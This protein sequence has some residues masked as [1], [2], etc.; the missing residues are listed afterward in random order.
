MSSPV[1]PRCNHMKQSLR[2]SPSLNNGNQSNWRGVQQR[3][4]TPD[5]AIGVGSR[6]LHTAPAPCTTPLHPLRTA[7]QG[8]ERIRRDATELR[9]YVNVEAFGGAVWT[10]DTDSNRCRGATSREQ[11]RPRRRPRLQ[12]RHASCLLHNRTVD[13]CRR[14]CGQKVWAGCVRFRS[15]VSGRMLG[16]FEGPERTQGGITAQALPVIVLVR[17]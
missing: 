7:W 10:H 1:H 2:E 13:C 12:L 8:S 14:F 5:A 4:T 11:P 9:A 15:T 16:E 17:C 6:S 3:L